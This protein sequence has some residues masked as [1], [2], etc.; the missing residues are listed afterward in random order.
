MSVLEI[1]IELASAMTLLQFFWLITTIF[2][3]EIFKYLPKL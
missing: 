2:N 1:E 3:L